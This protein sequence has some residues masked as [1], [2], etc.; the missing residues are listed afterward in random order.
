MEAELVDAFNLAI[1]GDFSFLMGDQTDDFLEFMGE[2]KFLADGILLQVD[3]EEFTAWMPFVIE[4]S[5]YEGVTIRSE[6]ILLPLEDAVDQHEK[7][8][9]YV[10]WPTFYVSAEVFFQ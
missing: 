9:D 10:G 5:T 3:C 2:Q 7:P 4:K 1:N 6:G 8:D